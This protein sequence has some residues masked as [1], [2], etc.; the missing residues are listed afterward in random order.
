MKPDDAAPDGWAAQLMQ[1][2]C[3]VSFGM[4]PFGRTATLVKKDNAAI[5]VLQDPHRAISNNLGPLTESQKRIVDLLIA[6]GV[7]TERTV[8][9]RHG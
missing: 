5:N 4:K 1:A 2:G 8:N 9:A 6:I 3:K 7:A